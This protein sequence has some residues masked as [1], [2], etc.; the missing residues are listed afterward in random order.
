M[1]TGEAAIATVVS[2]WGSA[3][4]PVGGQLVVTVDDRFEGSVSGGCVEVDVLVEAADVMASGQPKLL[5]FGVS[6]ET[7]WRAGLPCG[8]KIKVL[9]EPLTRADI[10]MIDAIIEA[11]RARETV[12]VTTR[13]ADGKR[14]LYKSDDEVPP[15]VAGH[16]ASGLIGLIET[17]DG[18]VFVQPLV[19]PAAHYRRRGDAHRSGVCRAG[20]AGRLFRH[21]R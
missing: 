6:E 11:R 20:A 8:G 12:V 9:V 5:E 10:A 4:V 13:I 16:L 3:P 21:R 1:S 15:E 17:P 18:E 7:A 14:Q 2:T 19:P